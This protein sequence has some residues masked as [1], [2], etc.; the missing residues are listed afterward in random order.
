[1]T[2]I[3][4]GAKYEENPMAETV[5][6]TVHTQIEKEIFG[7]AARGATDDEALLAE[8][9]GDYAS[10]K[11]LAAQIRTMKPGESL[12]YAGVTGLAERVA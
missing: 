11:Q 5:A 1:M 10:V 2:S 12:C 4:T 3:P 6:P 9:G 7:C 8:G